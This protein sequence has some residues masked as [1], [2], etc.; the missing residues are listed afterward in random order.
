[1]R[2]QQLRLPR[3]KF[4]AGINL[5]LVKA[6]VSRPALNAPEVPPGQ[7]GMD[8]ALSIMLKSRGA[9]E[10]RVLG[11]SPSINPL[12]PIPTVITAPPTL[13]LLAETGCLD[14]ADVDRCWGCNL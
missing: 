5:Q 13:S 8:P 3:A 14:V 11:T 7:A 12:L 2:Q 10:V 4:V 6:D 9:A 1:M